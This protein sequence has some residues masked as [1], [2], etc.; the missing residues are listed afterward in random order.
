MQNYVCGGCS[1]FF[2]FFSFTYLHQCKVCRERINEWQVYE[3][4]ELKIHRYVSIYV[5]LYW[6]VH[7]WMSLIML[8]CVSKMYMHGN[9][10]SSHL[11]L[12]TQSE[13]NQGIFL[14][15]L[16]K[17]WRNILVES[18]C[19]FLNNMLELFLWCVAS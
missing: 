17:W 12:K 10:A 13:Q 4:E 9:L 2:L 11:G 14:C 8:S 7:I 1:F 19:W 16:N 3:H 6:F 18:M 5:C 15:S